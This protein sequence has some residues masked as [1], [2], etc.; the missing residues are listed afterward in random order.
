MAQETKQ[1]LQRWKDLTSLRLK[2]ACVCVWHECDQQPAHIFDIHRVVH[3]PYL[4]REQVLT[5]AFGHA[6]PFCPINGEGICNKK[7]FQGGF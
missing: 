2:K 7:G 6:A 3:Y 5:Q 4:S 1:T